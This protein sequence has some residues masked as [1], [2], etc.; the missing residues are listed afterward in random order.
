[1]AANWYLKQC[2]IYNALSGS[3]VRLYNTVLLGCGV[4]ICNI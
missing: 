1:M 4:C 2:F 3:G